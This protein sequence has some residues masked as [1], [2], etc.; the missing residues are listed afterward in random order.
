MGW[1]KHHKCSISSVQ[2][3]YICRNKEKVVVLKVCF[4]SRWHYTGSYPPAEKLLL[5][6]YESGLW[7]SA[8]KSVYSAAVIQR[9][10]WDS[11]GFSVRLQRSLLA[12]RPTVGSEE[13]PARFSAP[14]SG[15]S[16]P[17]AKRNA[18]RPDSPAELWPLKI[19]HGKSSTASRAKKSV[20]QMSTSGRLI[21]VP[22]RRANSLQMMYD[23][24]AERVT[25]GVESVAG[26]SCR[27]VFASVFGLDQRERETNS[28]L[29]IISPFDLNSPDFWRICSHRFSHLGHTRATE[30]D[31]GA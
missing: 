28:V 31:G 7:K 23:G 4:A 15:K 25:W 17:A 10:L 9:V 11:W 18:S 27:P 22:T 13:S 16:Q 26:A 5:L 24:I 3:D 14:V 12:Y 30:W 2:P 21:T 1:N 20:T 19:K 8:T 29:N 6:L